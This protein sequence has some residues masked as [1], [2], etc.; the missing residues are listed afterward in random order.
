MHKTGL[1][2]AVLS[3]FS[4][5]AYAQSTSNVTFYGTVDEAV[6]YTNNG[7]SSPKP[8][9][10]VLVSSGIFASSRWGME[11]TEDL[12]GGLKAKFQLEAGFDADTGAMKTYSGNPSTATPAAPGGASI[13]G[14]FNRR[15]YVGLEGNFGG[16]FVGRDY[17]PLY[18][19]INRSDPLKLGLYG[20]VQE[21]VQLSG[22]GSDR[23]GRA[24]NAVFYVSPKLDGFQG[25][26]MYSLGSESPGGVGAA[27]KDAN[28][29]WGISGEYVLAG[30]TITGAYQQIQLPTVA[31]T[32]TAAIF[33]GAT[34]TRKDIVA[35]AKYV[36]GDYSVAGGYFNTK[37][38]IAHTDASDIWLGGTTKLGT[39]TVLVNFQRMRLD[40]AVG[41]APKATIYALSYVYPLSKRTSVYASSG[42][43]KNGSTA[44]FALAASDTT[45]AAAG[46]GAT[47]K[48]IALGITHTF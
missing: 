13:S 10:T 32:G 46:P 44:A 41:A 40:A 24:S 5:A 42:I 7:A 2:L 37:Q 18:W 45:V 39:G 20:N 29:M 4:T 35:G 34:G 22:T 28:H 1:A 17:T 19:A 33:T 47:V 15:S 30:L 36:F 26:A 16:V 11:G 21:I 14:L 38:P 48:A 12:G 6:A 3:I 9:N 43:V 31:G 27:P 25:R 23:F 8:S